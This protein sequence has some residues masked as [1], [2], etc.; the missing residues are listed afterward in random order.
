MGLSVFDERTAY[1]TSRL[2]V[3]A[4]G[5]AVL[6]LVPIAISDRR[7]DCVYVSN[8]DAIDHVISLIK[9]TDGVETSLGSTTMA[10]NTGYGGTA[11]RDI[12]IDVLNGSTAGLVLAPTELLGVQLAVAVTAT[13]DV[14]A[15]AVGGLF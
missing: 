4:D 15:T 7:I 6:P 2:V 10:T 11:S 12:L 9:T 13:F 14:S 1:N 8:R 3:P 5:T